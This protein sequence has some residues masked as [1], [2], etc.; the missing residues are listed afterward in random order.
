[1]LNLQQLSPTLPMNSMSSQF[2]PEYRMQFPAASYSID[3]TSHADEMQHDDAKVGSR[4]VDLRLEPSLTTY[5]TGAPW[6]ARA[7]WPP[8]SSGSLQR[9]QRPGMPW[10][11]RLSLVLPNLCCERVS[12]EL[13]SGPYQCCLLSGSAKHSWTHEPECSRCH[14]VV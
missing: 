9:K 12:F 6:S 11:T 1:M 13:P 10:P 8:R 3:F 4:H 2:L 14:H 7:P 5:E